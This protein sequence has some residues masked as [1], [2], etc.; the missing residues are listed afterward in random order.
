MA[1]VSGDEIDATDRVHGALL[2]TLTVIV[3]LVLPTLVTIIVHHRYAFR[4]GNWAWFEAG[5]VWLPI[6][7]L[8]GA[9]LGYRV[10]TRR[11]AGLAGHMWFTERPW[12]AT[13]SL[14]MW[15]VYAGTAIIT[16]LLY[17]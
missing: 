2:G 4:R 5:H 13:A 7:L 6:L 14:L 9:V 12:S 16:T 1:R 17:N 3:T 8:A 10:G 11:M 15:A